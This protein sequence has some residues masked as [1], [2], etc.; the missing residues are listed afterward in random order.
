MSEVRFLDDG[1]AHRFYGIPRLIRAS[2]VKITKKT[3]RV[4]A[5]RQ[6]AGSGEWRQ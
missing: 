1:L 4:G 3:G 2:A 6:S 5:R